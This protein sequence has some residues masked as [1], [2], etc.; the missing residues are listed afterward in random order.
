MGRLAAAHGLRGY[1]AVHLAS[2]EA[3]AGRDLV[4]A[5]GDRALLAAA[6]A[7]GLAT[8]STAG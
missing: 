2:A 7:L 1:D 6:T 8:A 4:L 3:L 5:A